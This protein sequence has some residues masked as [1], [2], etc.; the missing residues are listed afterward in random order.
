MMRGRKNIKL[1]FV[2][3]Y[4]FEAELPHADGRTDKQTGRHDEANSCVFA[5]LR[6]RL[7]TN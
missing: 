4:Q 6:R 2:K 3:S 5:V 7:K 1:N